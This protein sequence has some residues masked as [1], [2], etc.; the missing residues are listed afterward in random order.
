M[1]TIAAISTPNYASGISII[2]ISGDDA[3]AV[4][5]KVFRGYHKKSLA[6]LHGYQAAYGQV[7]ADDEAID[8]A[9]ALV[10]HAPKSYTGENVVEISCHGGIYITRKVLRA[11]LS[12]GATPAENGEFTKR[13]FLN[14]KLSLTQA[15]AVMDII[16]SQTK[17]SATVA[18]TNFEG[19]LYKKINEVNELLL[20]IAGHLSAWVDYP[21]EDIPVIEKNS[22]LNSL[23]TCITELELLLSGY[24]V[25]SMIKNGVKTTIVGKPNVGKS[26][27][28]NLLSRTEKSI[29]TEIAGTTR[30][31]VEQ[32]VMLGDICLELADTAGIH[33]TNDIVETVGVELARKR[34]QNSDLVLAVFDGSS[35]LSDNDKTLIELIADTPAIAIINKLDLPQK[36]NNE[37]INGKF[38][39]EVSISAKDTVS[40]SVLETEIKALLNLTE[41]D[42]TIATIANE[43]QHNCVKK[44]VSELTEAKRI[45]SEGFTLDAVTIMI[46]DAIAQLLELT[47][48]RITEKVVDNVFSHFCVGK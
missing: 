21:D 22:L 25:G 39:H 38:I 27:L 41:F 10:F 23:N 14:G 40:I 37:Y 6:T 46:E 4:A 44:A 13:A 19:A 1:N 9:V 29:V 24:D 36:F 47:G 12:A 20:N 2:R 5:D 17:L 33:S 15:E 3:L 42:A 28:M 30:D 31:V 16:N 32:T 26:T 43:R 11:V 48:E 7:F 45:L 18:K 34:L 8:E 35:P